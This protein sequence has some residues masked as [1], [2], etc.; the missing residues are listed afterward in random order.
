MVAQEP[1]AVANWVL[2][3]AM[4][5]PSPQSRQSGCAFPALAAQPETKA[6]ME[7]HRASCAVK[8]VAPPGQFV[9]RPMPA[10]GGGEGDR[11][12]GAE[13]GGGGDG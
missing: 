12:G 3:N 4:K 13:G 9:D 2:G 1:L 6:G 7:V 11:G 10:R 8:L 5:D